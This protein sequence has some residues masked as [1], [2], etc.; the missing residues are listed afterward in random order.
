MSSPLK[1]GILLH[2][3]HLIRND[4]L[5]PTFEEIWEEAVLAEKLGMDHVWV[6]D[7]VTV[8]DKARGDCLTM[9]TPV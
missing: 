1:F 5:T 8:L 6:G 7:S 9:I 3:R 2:T 4:G